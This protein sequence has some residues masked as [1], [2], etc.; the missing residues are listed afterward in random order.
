[1]RRFECSSSTPVGTQQSRTATSIGLERRE[2]GDSCSGESVVG[3]A[4]LPTYTLIDPLSRV[5]LLCL[6]DHHSH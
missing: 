5:R 3:L 2:S 1:M 6:L 4:N